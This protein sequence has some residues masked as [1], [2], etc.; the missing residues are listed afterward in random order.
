M[1]AAS[2]AIEH[3]RKRGGLARWTP[4]LV[5]L[6][7][8]AYG[9]G[10]CFHTS[11]DPVIA[12]KYSVGYFLVL[13]WWFVILTPSVFLLTRWLSHAS[14]IR[15]RSG[16]WVALSVPAKALIALVLVVLLG[17]AA[18]R[19]VRVRIDLLNPYVFHPY[20]QSAFKPDRPQLGF[21]RWGFRGEEIEREKPANTFRIF[22]FGG[23]TAACIESPFEKTHARLLEL[24]LRQEYPDRRIEV[25]NLGVPW[26]CSE[27]SLIKLICN[28]QDF[29]PD[30]V[31]FE[32][33]LNDMF[34][35]FA[36]DD[37][38][39]GPYR[40]DFGHYLGPV[41]GMV[42]G[43]FLDVNGFPLSR[44]TGFWC[45]DFR[46]D[47]VRIRGPDGDGI[48]GVGLVFMP[49][50]EEVS[51]DRWRSLDAFGRNVRSFVDFAKL[52]GFDVLVVSEPYLYRDDLTA[53]EREVL[54]MARTC[55]E[56][57]RRPDV[58]SLKRGMD[59]FNGR[60]RD[61]ADACGA[62]FFDLEKAIPKSLDYF[63]D[64]VHYTTKG[65]AAVATAVGNEVV[66]WGII[67][68]KLAP[69]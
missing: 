56:D 49:K 62:R 36:P 21:N 46:F 33:A 45:S 42:K 41:A 24:R 16:R 59:A 29:A 20:L 51:V 28:V 63:F 50:A 10:L 61:V 55:D 18:W 43:R 69:R 48:A 17:V 44:F 52:R 26:H 60:A 35:G 6:L 19:F 7:A 3:I 40:D 39:E 37:F 67:P 22:L 12:G 1:E 8:A 54:V 64:D 11:F 15:L 53:A 58:S 34:R 25:Q 13:C 9:V 68:R 57:G 27:H 23:S 66:N 30:L 2:P 47:C 32:H 5:A 14:Q 31:I 38:A 65:N 4:R